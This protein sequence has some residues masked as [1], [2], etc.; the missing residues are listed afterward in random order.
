MLTRKNTLYCSLSAALVV[1]EGKSF[2]KLWKNEDLLFKS[3]IFIPFN[4]NNCDWIL[5]VVNISQRA[6]GVLV[7]LGTDTHWTDTSIQRGYRISLTLMQMKFGLTDVK[8]V[9]IKY[10]KQPDNSSCSVM[11]CYCATMLSR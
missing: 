2:W 5:V 11:V 10:V 1:A 7:P 9:K 4:P 8:Q 6:I 3:F